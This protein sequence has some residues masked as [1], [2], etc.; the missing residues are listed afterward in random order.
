[1]ADRVGPAEQ[2]PFV[3]DRLEDEDVVLVQPA[4]DPGIVAEE[5][6]PFFDAGVLGTVLECP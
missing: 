5:H 3:E 4:A 2:A 1:M 6:V